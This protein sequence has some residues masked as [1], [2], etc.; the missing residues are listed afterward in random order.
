MTFGRRQ[1]DPGIEANP[2]VSCNQRVVVEAT[3]RERI[4]NDEKFLLGHYMP[5]KRNVARCFRR[6]EAVPGFEPLTVSVDQ[7]HERNWNVQDSRHE[8][9]E[10]IE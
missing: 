4:G 5:A 1:R 10:I 2:G 8:R 6:V 7:G 9:G 3:V